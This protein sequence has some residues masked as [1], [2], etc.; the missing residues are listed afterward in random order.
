MCLIHDILQ[1]QIDDGSGR[2]QQRPSYICLNAQAC[3]GLFSVFCQ[4]NYCKYC[5]FVVYIGIKTHRLQDHCNPTYHNISC[6]LLIGSVTSKETLGWVFCRS[7]NCGFRNFF[8][9]TRPLTLLEQLVLPRVSISVQLW[10]QLK[11]CD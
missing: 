5:V 7:G 3:F 10:P 6:R 9:S 1:Q 11:F 2:K 8:F 4:K